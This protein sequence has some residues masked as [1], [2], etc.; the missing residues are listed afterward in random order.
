VARLILIDAVEKVRGILLT[1]N[2]RIVGLDSLNRTCAFEAHFESILLRDPP[3]NLFSTASTQTGHLSAV[4]LQ[5]QSRNSLAGDCSLTGV[6][7][8]R[9]HWLCGSRNLYAAFPA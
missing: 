3:K 4:E 8:N 1:R 7:N 2:N 5:D 9:E 6:R